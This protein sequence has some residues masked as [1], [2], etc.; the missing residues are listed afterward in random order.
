M[1]L[2]DSSQAATGHPH[3]I[4]QEAVPRASGDDSSASDAGSSSAVSWKPRP[5]QQASFSPGLAH[6]HCVASADPWNDEL[7]NIKTGSIDC[8][9][10]VQVVV[11]QT[12]VKVCLTEQQHH[13]AAF[14]HTQLPGGVYGLR[15]QPYCLTGNSTSFFSNQPCYCCCCACLRAWLAG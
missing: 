7:A 1:D 14:L 13:D 10:E 6:V 12:P 9:V 4:R 8:A 2:S 11:Q 5:K 15:H 3:G